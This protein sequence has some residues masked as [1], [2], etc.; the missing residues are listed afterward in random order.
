MHTCENCGDEVYRTH[1]LYSDELN[2][3]YCFDC[4]SELRED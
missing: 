4:Y 2:G 3:W 1:G